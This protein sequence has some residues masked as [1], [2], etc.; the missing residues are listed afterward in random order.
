MKLGIFGGTFDPPHIG[1]LILAAEAMDQLSLDQVQWVLTLHP[2]H[3]EKSRIT[4]LQHRLDMVSAAIDGNPTFSLSRVDIDRPAPHYAIDTVRLV[5][6]E[7]PDVEITYLMGGDSLEN[8]PTWFRPNE[9]V[10]VCHGIGVMNRPGWKYDLGALDQ[11]IPGIQTKIQMINAPM[12][13][14][15]ATQI[16]ARIR[17]NRPYQYFLLPAVYEIILARGLYKEMKT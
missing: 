5:N 4:P 16:R 3:K 8:L 12:L 11:M 10:Q 15:S 9:L 2:P 13:D 7:F 6:K 14:I 1:H 17:T